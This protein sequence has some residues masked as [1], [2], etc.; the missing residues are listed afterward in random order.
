MG[1]AAQDIEKA[2]LDAAG[3]EF[4]AASTSFSQES[5][6][7]EKIA[8]RAGVGRAT[9]YRYFPGRSALVS[10]V[11]R[12]N[13]TVFEEVSSVEEVSQD[14]GALRALLG[15]VLSSGL[16]L[17]PLVAQARSLPAAEREK[18]RDAMV[19]ALTPMFGRA[20]RRGEL[21]PDFQP[22]DLLAVTELLTAAVAAMPAEQHPV[23]AAER[24]IEL[25]L[26]GLVS[27]PHPPPPATAGRPRS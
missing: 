8:R 1:A 23:D 4:A 5:P 18:L 15:A 19:G 11:A 25:L 27:S 21:R 10:A 24:L 13:V 26:D 7:M 2:L 6:S 20:Q 9:A 16:T 12:R 17:R 22:A 3:S 14:A